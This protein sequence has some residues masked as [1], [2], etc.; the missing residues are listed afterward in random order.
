MKIA[1]VSFKNKI[2]W[3]I[4]E[5]KTIRFIRGE[6]FGRIKAGN[7]RVSLGKVR[8][9]VPAT[10]SK[11][12]LAGLNYRDHARELNMKLPKEPVIFLKPPSSLIA[13]GQ[14]I[15]Y[16]E[17]AG[18]IDYEGELA[19]VIKKK[20][21]KIPMSKAVDYILGYTC[22]NDITARDLQKKDG[23][24]TRS[25]SFDTF[26]PVGPWLE[27][28]ACPD[29]LRIRTYLNGAPRQDSSCSN[30]IFP[31]DYLVSFIS[32]V[33]TLNPGDIISTGTP[34]GVGEINP[35]DKIC[36]EIDGIGR[37]ENRVVK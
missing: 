18:R 17:R 32:S 21:R 29:K 33:M 16:P 24:W 3:A 28:Q 13:Q 34:P 9:L 26:C 6:P 10:P 37:L 12:I 11:I 23:Q 31:V 7:T 5:D 30:F 22:L 20:C 8:L 4:I 15:I 14:D 35:Q 19:L 2:S 36:V 27:T 1:R 25:K